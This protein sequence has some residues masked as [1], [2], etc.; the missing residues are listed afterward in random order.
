MSPIGLFCVMAAALAAPAAFTPVS[1]QARPEGRMEPQIVLA[2]Q[3]APKDKQ[4]RVTFSCPAE[5][6]YIDDN[7][8]RGKKGTLVLTGPETQ[9]NMEEALKHPEKRDQAEVRLSPEV[10]AQLKKLGITDVAAHFKGHTVKA[11]G[12]PTSTI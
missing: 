3:S 11:T 2:F 6:A 5:R 10:V 4:G 12:K 7:A 8:F 1:F 9:V